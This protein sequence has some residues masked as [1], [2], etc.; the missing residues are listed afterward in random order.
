MIP[1]VGFTNPAIHLINVLLPLPDEPVN[2]V[3]PEAKVPSAF[4]IIEGLA[5]VKENVIIVP[6]NYALNYGTRILL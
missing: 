6:P 5:M 1:V 2:T 3:I 4:T